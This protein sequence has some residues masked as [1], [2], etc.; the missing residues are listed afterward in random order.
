MS[1]L[2]ICTQP[3]PQTRITHSLTQPSHKLKSVNP[4]ERK[5]PIEETQ[6]HTE[7]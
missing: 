7:A 5:K 3:P 2:L 1:T 6:K 4:Y